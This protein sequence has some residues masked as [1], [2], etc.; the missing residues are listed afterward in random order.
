M[1]DITVGYCKPLIT[2]LRRARHEA[3]QQI[4]NDDSDFIGFDP[5]I[6]DIV[7]CRSD[8]Y[9]ELDEFFMDVLIGALPPDPELMGF[10]RLIEESIEYHELH[11]IIKNGQYVKLVVDEYGYYLAQEQTNAIKLSRSW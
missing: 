4:Y 9:L 7:K 2:A 6:F 5:E 11:D 8:Y 10:H 1:V 3:F